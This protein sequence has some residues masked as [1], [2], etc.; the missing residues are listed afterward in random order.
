MLLGGGPRPPGMHFEVLTLLAPAILGIAY[1]VGVLS[2]LL[3]THEIAHLPWGEFLQTFLIVGAPALAC[4]AA[5]NVFSRRRAAA[6]RAQTRVAAQQGE[7]AHH[8][9]ASLLEGT[10]QSFLGDT[11]CL[12]TCLTIR[13]ADGA[14]LLRLRRV[15]TFLLVQADGGTRLVEGELW[16]AATPTE[17]R[18]RPLAQVPQVLERL[19]LDPTALALPR[20]ATAEE[21]LI[22]DG[23]AVTIY[24]A[25]DPADEGHPAA[26]HV[27]REGGQTSVLRGEVG[28]PLVI[29]R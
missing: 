6:A 16:C 29:E 9:A 2:Y 5:F 14:T 18:P 15:A 8:G 26:A 10:V 13:G 20:G 24:A 7:H 4:L 27:Y 25:A 12:V 23:D 3:L 22:A 17:H 19:G 21:H 1:T 28:R 11:A